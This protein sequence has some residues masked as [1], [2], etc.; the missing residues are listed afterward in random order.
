VKIKFYKANN[1]NGFVLVTSMMVLIVLTL[2][3]V[4]AMNNS[5]T[6][7]MISGNDRIHKQ[8]FYNADGGTEL[9]QHVV[10]QNTMCLDANG[11]TSNSLFNG[12]PAALLNGSVRVEDLIFADATPAIVTNVSDNIR[13]FA[14]Y[15]EANVNDGAPHTNFLTTFTTA[16]SAGNPQQMVSGYDAPIGQ[17][18]VAGTHRRYLIA[19]QHFGIDNSQSLVQVRWRI[20][21]SIISSAASTDCIY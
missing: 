3:G 5:N 21:N 12:N 15:P 20:D 16:L 17:G 2:I 18:Q 19:S 8:T 9:A 13:A 1:E 11:F 10:Y 6:E 4:L 14:Y 7:R